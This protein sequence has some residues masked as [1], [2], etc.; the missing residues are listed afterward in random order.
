MGPY[1]V[2][3][4]NFPTLTHQFS[5]IIT[6]NS[7]YKNEKTKL[8]GERSKETTKKLCKQD[9]K[10]YFEAKNF[11]FLLRRMFWEVSSLSLFTLWVNSFNFEGIVSLMFAFF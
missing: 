7:Q 10:N 9:Q 3:N 4:K 5:E 6:V 2:Q 11:L 1:S 8:N